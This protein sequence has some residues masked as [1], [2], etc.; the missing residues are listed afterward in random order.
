MSTQMEQ[1]LID[2][3][4]TARYGQESVRPTKTAVERKRKWVHALAWPTLFVTVVT[5][6]SS[7]HNPHVAAIIDIVSY[8][9]VTAGTV[10]RLWCGLYVFGR[11]AKEFCQDGPYS[12]C[13]NPLYVSAF[14]SISGLAMASDRAILMVSFP[15]L[16]GAY[17][18]LVI[19]A[20]ENRMSLLFGRDYEAYCAR[21]PR[22]FPRL[23]SYRARA[24]VA[25][26]PDHYLSHIVKALG[27]FWLLFL[28]R[29]AEAM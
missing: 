16:L 13:R 5:T 9:L 7:V 15:L 21:T 25:V 12:I 26:D 23:A 28:L 18:L 6:K 24:T 20:E 29:L 11:K 19:K 2:T 10:G 4:G 22:I 1:G 27:Y 3:T 14:L 17:Y 8:I